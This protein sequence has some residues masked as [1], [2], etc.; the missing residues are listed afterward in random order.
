MKIVLIGAGNAAT[1]LGRRIKT[2]G[3]EILQ[4]YN[5]G[6]A[7]ARL[8]AQELTSDFTNNFDTITRDAD[9][10][11]AALADSALPAIP[12]DL[13]LGQR[14]VV[15]TAGSVSKDVLR[16]ISGN[17]G[18]LYPLQS[19]RKENASAATEIPLL[20]DGSN[21]AVV[22]Q[23]ESFAGT[24]STKVRQAD[25]ETRLKL[26]AAAV[27]VNNFT[28]HL[29]S[30]TEDYCS[31]EQLDFTLLL[32]LIDETA[33]RLHRYSARNMQ[34]GPAVRKDM[35]TINRHLELLSV[36]PHLKEIY[37][38]LTTSIFNNTDS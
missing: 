6:E 36:H 15:H 27:I 29:Y 18:V 12:K 23:L 10:Y 26:H 19:L 2:A 32:P 20:V 17:Y 21:E 16:E 13:Q 35:S 24:I 34:T 25:D 7:A 3:H 4:V 9:I 37:Q 38:Q 33:S 5:R 11:I 14:I 8:L 22:K 28:N 1:V 31:K 30:L